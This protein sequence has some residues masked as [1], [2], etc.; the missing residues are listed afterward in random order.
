MSNR[1][2]YN[3]V[4]FK[5]ENKIVLC[6]CNSKWKEYLLSKGYKMSLSYK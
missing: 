4:V 1:I 3:Y 5:I 2:F 6:N